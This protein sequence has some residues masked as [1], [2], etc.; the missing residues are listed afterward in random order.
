MES[1][2]PRRPPGGRRFAPAIALA[3][4]AL[5]GLLLLGDPAAH[6]PLTLLCLAA[7]FAALVQASR[8]L[9]LQPSTATILVIAAGVRLALLPL[10][11]T[12]SD[13]LWRYLWDGRVAAAGMNPYEHP[14]DA[15]ALATVRDDSEELWRKVDHRGVATLYPPLAVALWSVVV[16]LPVPELAWKALA[17]AADL[18]T[19]WFLVLLAAELGVGSRRV[20]WYGWNPLVVLETAGMGHVDAVAVPFAVACVLLLVARRETLVAGVLAAGGVL[21]K[22][23]PVAAIPLWA[24]N[25]ERPWRFT[26]VAAGVVTI[27]ALPVLVTTGGV[28][29]G[30]VTYAV[31]WEFNGPLYAPLWR[32]VELSGV[33]ELLRHGLDLMKNWS[34]LDAVVDRL[35]PYVYPRFLAKLL[36]G[37]AAAAVV[38]I[39]ARRR[40]VVAASRD[41]FGGLLLCSATVYPWYLLWVL[42][43][44]ALAGGTAWLVLSGSILVIY[45]F[46]GDSSL[47]WPWMHLLAWTPPLA[48]WV[49]RRRS[50][51]EG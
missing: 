22:L 20:V 39:T 49:W 15:A 13:D 4:L 2:G 16:R 18:L 12:L 19:C 26:A 3:V 28:P 43:W 14:P 35:Y 21:A 47:A 17:A 36:L 41:L 34:G 30:L 25:A 51:G 5:A 6:A 37:A 48:V 45:L 10:A 1:E 42:P 9:P 11:P 38:V 33:V 23:A 7:G 40:D 31:S 46:P 24:R 44:A 29:S 27:A 8:V 50:G 32:L